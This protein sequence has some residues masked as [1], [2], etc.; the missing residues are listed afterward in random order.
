MTALYFIKCDFG[1][2]GH[3]FVERDVND[4][5]RASTIADI[6][7]SQLTD[8]VQILEVTP[9]EHLTNDVTEEI[10]RAAGKWHE[11]EAPCLVPSRWD[12]VKHEAA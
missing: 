8:I 4:M 11:I 5:D 6:R 7:S 2:L 1:R 3:A 10:L 12:R 9:D